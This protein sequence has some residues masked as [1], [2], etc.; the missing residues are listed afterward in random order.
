M[1]GG[2]DWYRFM[3]EESMSDCE[4]VESWK[5]NGEC[6]TDKNKNIRNEETARGQ[7]MTYTRQFFVPL[8]WNNSIFSHPT[9]HPYPYSHPTVF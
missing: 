4:N 5:V 1:E 8:L 7:L 3:R 9:C 2:R 6:I